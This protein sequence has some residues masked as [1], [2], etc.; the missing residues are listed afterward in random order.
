MAGG[1]TGEQVARY[2]D[3]AGL[4]NVQCYLQ[5]SFQIIMI[6]ASH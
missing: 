4:Y 3:G 2:T 5:E 6:Q 1:Y